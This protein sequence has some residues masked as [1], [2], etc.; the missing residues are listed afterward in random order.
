MQSIGLLP[1]WLNDKNG[2]DA[3]YCLKKID[4]EMNP[5]KSGDLKPLTLKNLSGAFII[6][7]VG[8]AL[9]IAAFIVEVVHGRMKKKNNKSIIEIQG[10]AKLI[11]K[12]ENAITIRQNN[13]TNTNCLPHVNAPSIVA[14]H[15]VKKP[16]EHIVAIVDIEF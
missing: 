12:S 8:Y 3:T 5:K 4:Q 1:L 14:Q 9:A 16:A 11:G 7:G 13:N 15:A 2:I 6:L 10:A